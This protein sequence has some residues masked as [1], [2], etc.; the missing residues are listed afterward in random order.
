MKPLTLNQRKAAKVTQRQIDLAKRWNQ[1][2]SLSD[3]VRKAAFG[4]EGG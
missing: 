3:A 4:A 1:N 2:G